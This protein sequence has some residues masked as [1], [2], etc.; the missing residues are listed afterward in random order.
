MRA[1]LG[2][3][4]S[5]SVVSAADRFATEHTNKNAAK[6]MLRGDLRILLMPCTFFPFLPGHLATLGTMSSTPL[7]LL[8]WF[9]RATISRSVDRRWRQVSRRLRRRGG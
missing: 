4:G 3:G 9:Q 5:A 6:T 7:F 8:Y 1:A 2:S